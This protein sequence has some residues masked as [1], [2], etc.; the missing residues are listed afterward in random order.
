[1]AR[2]MSIIFSKNGRK[3]EGGMRRKEEIEK[4]RK[5]RGGEE[6][7]GRSG[8]REKGRKGDLSKVNRNFFPP[9]VDH[10]AHQ[11]KQMMPTRFILRKSISWESRL[12]LNNDVAG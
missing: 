9:P 2:E 8:E 1:M 6:E 10:C 5:G 4:G 3:G 12:N 7:K 11:S